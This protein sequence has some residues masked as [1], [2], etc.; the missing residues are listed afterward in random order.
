MSTPDIEKRK[1]RRRSARFYVNAN[2]PVDPEAAALIADFPADEDD[3]GLTPAHTEA[4]A[5]NRAMAKPGAEKRD[6]GQAEREHLA[7]EGRA[8]VNADGHV[9]Y[10]VAPGN[11]EDAENALAL[12]RSGHG[13]TAAARRMLRRVA[14]QEGWQDIL[15][16]LGSKKG[17]AGNPVPHPDG[18][19]WTDRLSPSRVT[20]QGSPSNGDHNAA[21]WQDPMNVPGP[22]QLALG[23]PD[24][25][26]STTHPVAL[27][28]MRTSANPHPSDLAGVISGV[29]VALSR[30][31][32]QA[33]S[34]LG[35]PPANPFARLAPHT[36]PIGQDGGPHSLS[37]PESQ[38]PMSMK[39]SDRVELMR[40]HLFPGSGGTR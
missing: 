23:H 30:L 22:C 27:G 29:P 5:R 13:D 26:Q 7:R 35:G 24:M 33:A 10:P 8:V 19:S 25:R 3:D 34:G 11:H 15:D 9:S 31:D 2:R 21:A 18:G 36:A 12:I 32:A 38:H 1:N 37:Q 16:G 4:R 6:V 20:G 14:R 28:V 17:A 39:N 40:R